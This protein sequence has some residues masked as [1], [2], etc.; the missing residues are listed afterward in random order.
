MTYCPPFD[1]DWLCYV[2]RSPSAAHGNEVECGIYQ[3]WVKMQVQF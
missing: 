2:C 3:G 1:K